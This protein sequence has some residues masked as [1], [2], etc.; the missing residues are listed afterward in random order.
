MG[1]AACC[2]TDT[3][4][5]KSNLNMLGSIREN[6]V[7]SSSAQRTSMLTTPQVLYSP[8]ALTTAH[9]IQPQ[10]SVENVFDA[11][12]YDMDNAYS[13]P[14]ETLIETEKGS[15]LVLKSTNVKNRLKNI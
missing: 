10:G 14:A 13:V 5:Q 3:R 15:E 7:S 9:S 11:T 2:T 8:K 4:E 1:I 12:K 6:S